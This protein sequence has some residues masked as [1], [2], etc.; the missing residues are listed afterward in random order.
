M[1]EINQVLPRFVTFIQV[2]KLAGEQPESFVSFRLHSRPDKLRIWIAENF[3][4]IDEDK[5]LNES[6]NFGLCAG[7]TGENKN[8]IQLYFMCTRNQ[9]PLIFDWD[10]SRLCAL[11][12]SRN[13]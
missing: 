5:L 11:E 3:V 7:G 12:K 1:F 9:E 2:E 6:D 4:F 13:C 8:R 10:F